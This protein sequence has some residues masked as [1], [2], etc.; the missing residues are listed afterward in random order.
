MPLWLMASRE[1]AQRRAVRAILE[2]LAH[3]L[4]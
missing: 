2:M 3:Q 1:A 4:G